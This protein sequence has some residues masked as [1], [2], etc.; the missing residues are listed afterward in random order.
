MK[1]VEFTRYGPPSV[2]QL[3]EVEKPTPEGDRVLVRIHAAAANP[4]DWHY[5]RAD[6]FFIRFSAGLLR[7]KQTILGAD[8]AGVVEAVGPDVTRLTPGDAVFGGIGS[9][10]YAEYAAPPE[11]ALVHKPESISFEE[12]A[13]APVAAMTA[14]QILRDDVGLHGEQH[15]LINGASGGV[16]TYAVQVAKLFGAQVTGV[17]STRNVDLVSSLGAD[18]VIDYTRE[19]FTQGDARYDVILD[20]VGNRSSR[21]CERVLA[22]GGLY[23]LNAGVMRRILQVVLRGVTTDHI[24]MA[25]TTSLNIDDMQWLADHLADGR[26]T[27]VIDRRYALSD[28]PEAIAYVEEGH[29]RGKVIVTVDGG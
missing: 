27:S 4:L 26:L 20:N 22:E 24:K 16:G 10:G 2:M 23:M 29:A 18:R 5:L 13:A 15:I 21:E 14:L 11:R 17:C 28:V 25:S 19:D 6:P 7:P 9:G 1:A 3:T 8:I 12:A